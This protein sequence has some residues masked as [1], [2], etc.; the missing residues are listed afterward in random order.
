LPPDDAVRVAAPPQIDATSM[1]VPTPEADDTAPPVAVSTFAAQ[2]P[3]ESLPPV[4]VSSFEGESPENE[5]P[6][7]DHNNT[8]NQMEPSPEQ[9]TTQ[10]HVEGEQF[11]EPPPEEQRSQP[12]LPDGWTEV[13][14]PPSG[15]T[16][17]YNEES[18]VSS[19]E[20]PAAEELLSE[21]DTQ[22]I[23]FL[24]GQE[25][26]ETPEQTLSQVE[27]DEAGDVVVDSL[28]EEEGSQSQPALPFGW[29]ELVDPS[30][31][32]S[33][34]LNV[35]SGVTTWERPNEEEPKNR[36]K[37]AQVANDDSTLAEVGALPDGWTEEIDGVSG[38]TYYYHVENGEAS[39]DRPGALESTDTT[40][41]EDNTYEQVHAAGEEE[42]DKLEFLGETE[43]NK[44]E[45][46]TRIEDHEDAG[47]CAPLPAGWLE[48]V[49][50]RSGRPYYVNSTENV[51][52]WERPQVPNSNPTVSDAGVDECHMAEAA[53]DVAIESASPQTEDR[54][55]EID[56]LP[57]STSFVAAAEE[58][59][60]ETARTSEID[61]SGMSST[62]DL[63]ASESSYE[64]AGE[65]DAEG[66]PAE[67]EPYSA[68]A[69][70]LG[71]EL[72]ENWDQLVDP[73]SGL[74]YYY[75]V[76]DGTVTWDRPVVTQGSDENH[77]Q[78]HQISEEERRLSE[79]ELSTADIGNP[80]ESTSQHAEDTNDDWNFVSSMDA[81]EVVTDQSH[82]DGNP[83]VQVESATSTTEDNEEICEQQVDIPRLSPDW[84]EFI[85]PDSGNPYNLN[86]VTNAPTW[87]MPVFDE[88][89]LDQPAGAPVEIEQPVPE[90]NQVWTTDNPET[91]LDV[92]LE[93]FASETDTH[94]AH[95]KQMDDKKD[96]PLPAE[97]PLP[98]GWAEMVDPSSGKTYYVNEAENQ[99]TWERPVAKFPT[100]PEEAAAPYDEPSKEGTQWFDEDGSGCSVST[101]SNSQGDEYGLKGDRSTDDKTAS[102]ESEQMEETGGQ[103]FSQEPDETDTLT[104]P[105][106]WIEFIDVTSGRPY[107]VNEADNTTSWEKP[108][109]DRPEPDTE[110]E[111]ETSNVISKD[112]TETAEEAVLSD[113]QDISLSV[114]RETEVVH[115]RDKVEDAAGGAVSVLPNG[116]IEEIDPA[117]G[118]PYYIN[119]ADNTTTWERPGSI[120]NEQAISDEVPH[121]LPEET[122]ASASRR[123]DDTVDDYTMVEHSETVPGAEPPAASSRS[124]LLDDGQ[125]ELPP[126]WVE[127][128]DDAS[129]SSYY[130]NEA[131]Y[132]STW[133]RPSNIPNKGG[134]SGKPKGD[135]VIEKQKTSP[136][137]QETKNGIEDLPLPSGW[138][139][140]VDPGT[141]KTY[142]VHGASNVTTWD[143]PN[144]AVTSD[145]MDQNAASAG[146]K[147]RKPARVLATFGFGGKLCVWK[148][149]AP[150]TVV[151]H[152]AGD[153]MKTDPVVLAEQ[154]KKVSNIFGPLNA[155]ED[156]AVLNHIESKATNDT[157]NEAPCHDLLWSLVLIAAKSHGRLRSDDGVRNPRSPEAGV[158]SLLLDDTNGEN[159]DSQPG[160]RRDD[161]SQDEE[162]KGEVAD[163]SCLK[164]VEKLLLW[165]KREEAVQEAIRS[166][167]FAMA[168]LVASMCDRATF[169][170]ATKEFADDILS[171]GSPLHTLAMLFSGQLQAPA[172]SSLDRNGAKTSISIWDNGAQQLCLSWRQHLAATIS[173]RTLGWDRIVLSLGDHLLDSGCIQAA[174][175]CFVVCG[176]PVTSLLHPSSRISLVGCD[177]LV[178]MDAALMTLEGVSS[179]ER[180]EAYEW[181][182]RR[183]NPNAAIPSLQPFKL[184][185]AMLLADMGFGKHAQMY[186]RS[187]RQCC[188][189]EE[190]KKSEI[191]DSISFTVWA[192]SVRNSFEDALDEFEDRLSQGK[193]RGQAISQ[194]G[195]ES[196]AL[197][198]NAGAASPPAARKTAPADPAVAV[199]KQLKVK[200]KRPPSTKVKP[201]EPC[202]DVNATFL[203]AQSNLLDVTASSIVE[204]LSTQPTK[205]DERRRSLFETAGRD[206]AERKMDSNATEKPEVVRAT[207]AP[208]TPGKRQMPNESSASKKTDV[209]KNESKVK[210]PPN[211]APALLGFTKSKS[212]GASPER[213]PS[214]DK[215][216]Q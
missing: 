174:H 13:T 203:S 80:P 166:K 176:C 164:N 2:G 114:E 88:A 216:K 71:A 38:R 208:T 153:L 113:E 201:D 31:G 68:E 81:P 70:T 193:L 24:Y 121:S 135:L 100:G 211:S 165:G 122:S 149:Q 175:F 69:E 133:E 210:P 170:E 7:S 25:E 87:E 195:S 76:V 46:E 162:L 207:L 177:H 15:K 18:G 159:F 60:S 91:N 112:K 192:L 124:D 79:S 62:T 187:I 63:S 144:D 138:A 85:H 160:I 16:Y 171:T 48:H 111:P 53:P 109:V 72:P 182:K 86:E 214:S 42:A 105:P 188:G 74:T 200:V 12:F 9:T 77:N 97:A 150:S 199:N 212:A 198:T 158:I 84:K 1:Y 115:D 55:T 27:E 213:A 181:A 35:E 101:R 78:A 205:R 3:V 140:D 154:K 180:T 132:V 49:D 190:T 52:S 4:N 106:G 168:L 50:P 26:E 99:S 146:T 51:T 130:M 90:V 179:Y 73:G 59:A 194:F 23:E 66:K 33:Y 94:A 202:E 152:R 82:D 17:Y 118:N 167:N 117:S 155:C 32:I 125:A 145:E 215:S 123:S 64:E 8:V 20:R 128:F 58:L 40:A 5:V 134:L 29:T 186:V 136:F 95:H 206:A 102:L 197:I 44:R 19:W 204:E 189:L 89:T 183:G 172:D 37:G 41:A 184:M 67:S 56:S 116:W 10:E 110:V 54:Q 98:S 65:E 21:E 196:S 47:V 151:V 104:L 173:N 126:G 75:N 139:E 28:N 6:E 83:E 14:D 103:K 127:L 148:S 141:G 43:Q 11:I 156:A 169:Q 30:T 161:T 131:E 120:Q 185:Y 45:T 93:T 39:C 61:S 142:Y 92:S 147:E 178:P 107:Y 96:A 191:P 157:L 57:E 108:V 36:E 119:E 209:V 34:F 22:N 143:R 137:H 129:R 163:L